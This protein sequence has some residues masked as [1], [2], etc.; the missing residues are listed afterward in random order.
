MIVIGSIP[1]AIV[2]LLLKDLF[3][4]VLSNLLVVAIGFGIT[5][6]FLFIASLRFKREG[7]GKLT[8]LTVL[9]I[10]SAQALA[11]VPGISRSGA[12][13]AAGLLLGLSEKKAMKFAF[14]LSIPIIF[15]ANV[16]AVGNQTLPPSLIWATIVSFLVGLASIHVV[17]RYVLTKRKNLRWFGAYCLGLAFVLYLFVILR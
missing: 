12:T 13:I 10:G 9:I 17:F 14:L 16:I 6:L 8:I 5:G 4:T 15:G 3:D 2:G 7:S 1:A 11:I